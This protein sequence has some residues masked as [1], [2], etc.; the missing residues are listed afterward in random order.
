LLFCLGVSPGSGVA[1][2]LGAFSGGREDVRPRFDVSPVRDQ[3]TVNSEQGSEIHAA[4]RAVEGGKTPRPNISAPALAG[5]N[6]F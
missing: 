4:L 1:A 3:E 2:C 5:G 6:F